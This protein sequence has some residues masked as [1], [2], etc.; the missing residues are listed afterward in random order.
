[1]ITSSSFHEA[2][3]LYEYKP[4]LLLELV[5]NGFICF[6]F[7]N[8]LP[9]NT[10]KLSSVVNTGSEKRDDFRDSIETFLN[11]FEWCNQVKYKVSAL[12][13]YV[14]ETICVSILMTDHAYIFNLNM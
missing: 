14:L 9:Q 2:N 6:A 5:C 13:I 11:G 3:D 8:R 10:V 7:F 4:V 12:D 1:M